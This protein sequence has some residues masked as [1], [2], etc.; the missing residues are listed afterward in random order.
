MT[1]T[2]E[3]VRFRHHYLVNG[4]ILS[5]CTSLNHESGIVTVGWSVFNPEDPRWVRK[6]GNNI[7]RKRMEEK[8]LVFLLTRDEPCVCDYI[9]LRALM[10]I[11]GSAKRK[12]GEGIVEDT[13]QSIPRNTLVAIEYEMIRILSL[14]GERVGLPSITK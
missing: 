7:A 1:N 5:V 11:L 2:K 6:I 9:S 12:S 8:P 10:L 14:L 3:A 4:G 13:T